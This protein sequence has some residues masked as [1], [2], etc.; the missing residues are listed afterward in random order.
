MYGYLK[1]APDL[2]A[3]VQIDTK[4]PA[5][6]HLY[7]H[8]LNEE[9]LKECSLAQIRTN[10]DVIDFLVAGSYQRYYTQYCSNY[11]IP[12]SPSDI[13]RM[14]TE[15]TTNLYA[16]V[17]ICL[18]ADSPAIKEYA[19]Y[20]CQLRSSVLSMPLLDDGL[21]YR[22]VELSD[23]EISRMES[24]KH[25]FIPSFTSTSTDPNRA[26]SKN[27]RLIIKVPYGCKY[28]C[29]ITPDLSPYHD[30]EREVL[31]CCYSGYT[32][33]RY[34]KV[35]DIHYLTLYLDEQHPCNTRFFD[36]IQNWQK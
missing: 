18:A 5:L 1:L 29:S 4:A 35:A 15:H 19:D 14:Y 9:A 28:A 25:F 27:A 3:D 24:L 21:L 34:E 17:N 11:L 23:L 31:L 26:Y 36:H 6:R 20:I 30:T 10:D 32:L 7:S 8:I 13:I 12:D 22:G 2:L 16:K 33:E